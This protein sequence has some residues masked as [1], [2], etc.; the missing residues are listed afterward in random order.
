LLIKDGSNI[1]AIRYHDI[2]DNQS[3]NEKLDI[4]AQHTLNDIEFKDIAM[5]ENGDWINQRDKRYDRY[6]SLNDSSEGIFVNKLVGFNTNRDFWAFNFSRKSVA[7]N[8]ERMISN[9]NSEIKRLENISDGKKRLSKLNSSE[10]YISWSRGLK[11][12]FIKSEK[13]TMNKESI[14]ILLRCQENLINYWTR[15]V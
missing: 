14:V 5:D 2:G 10:D 15:M 11:N 4:L 7:N 13:I 9:Y 12:K 8:I 6:I 3:K 1:H